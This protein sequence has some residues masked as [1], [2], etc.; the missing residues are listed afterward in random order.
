MG[1]RTYVHRFAMLVTVMFL[2]MA[3][4]GCGDDSPEGNET[5]KGAPPN[6]KG[7]EAGGYTVEAGKQRDPK[8]VSQ[9][10][11][12]FS[13]ESPPV[14]ILS[15]DDSGFRVEKPT[16]VVAKSDTDLK[17]LRARHFSKGV[18]RE[19]FAPVDFESRQIVGL[20][21]PVEPRGTIVIV[22]DVFEEGGKTVI[23]AKRLLAGKG[24]KTSKTKPR[25]FHIVET[26]KMKG[27]PRLSLQD[28]RDAAC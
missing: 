17:S 5:G 10:A 12:N 20:F 22:A 26:R 9:E 6:V 15:G 27:Q 16:V 8:D 11:E 24:C 18:P 21:L 1:G 13:D 7:E 14:Q 19:D 28:E 4:V 25:P 2:A 23:K 3:G